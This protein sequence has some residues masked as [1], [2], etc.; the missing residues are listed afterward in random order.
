MFS[1]VE[2]IWNFLRVF[3]WKDFIESTTVGR[4]TVL[5]SLATNTGWFVQINDLQLS[6]FAT[7]WNDYE[8]L[9]YSLSLCNITWMCRLSVAFIPVDFLHRSVVV[10]IL[11]PHFLHSSSVV[12]FLIWQHCWFQADECRAPPGG[13]GGQ[14]RGP[15]AP[16]PPKPE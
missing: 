1:I 15:W 14:K 16:S 4:I 2:E 9:L 3:C 5:E 8:P 7:C 13:T 12:S 11:Y 6:A 10:H